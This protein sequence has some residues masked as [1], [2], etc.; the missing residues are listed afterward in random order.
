[1]TPRPTLPEPDDLYRRI[2]ARDA[3]LFP[4]G[5]AA[6]GRLSFQDAP[7]RMERE[8]RNLARFADSV[9]EAEVAVIGVGVAPLAAGALV[10]AHERVGGGD[11]RVRVCD[12]AEPTALDELA[13]DT[14]FVVVVAAGEGRAP[15]GELL[16]AEALRRGRD[17]RR[18]AVVAPAHSRLAAQAH[19]AGVRRVFTQPADAGD[20]FGAL[21][22]AGALPAAL[23]GY[24]VAELCGRVIDVDGPAAVALGLELA[25]EVG[26]GRH[27]LALPLAESDAGLGPYLGALVAGALGG[28]RGGAVALVA[29]PDAPGAPTALRRVLAP[30]HPARLGEAIASV[31]LA[32]VAAG[33]ALGLDPFAGEQPAWRPD[34]AT[35][36]AP[37]GPP[38]AVGGPED[39]AAFLDE[40]AGPEDL[41]SVAIDL[42]AAPP[43]LAAL[44][45]WLG[46][47]WSGAL[48]IGPGDRARHAWGALRSA[49]PTA[50]AVTLVSRRPVGPGA[51]AAHHAAASRAEH[52]LLVRAEQPVCRIALEDLEELWS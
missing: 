5:A 50:G 13:L 41:C 49:G 29:P 8:A 44:E 36:T 14:A 26:E 45:G 27:I 22:V 39:L 6:T 9:D 33:Y 19:G 32:V 23:A 35:T 38:A 31:E 7:R 1:M 4:L 20:R 48:L 21:G 52:E 30:E 47:R 51:L 15:E 3:G 37:P 17:P 2:R 24:D 12:V 46:A 11:R 40:R 34:P 10:A 28:E 25:A 18:I 16:L 42:P 43:T